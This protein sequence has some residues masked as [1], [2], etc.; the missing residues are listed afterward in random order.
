MLKC[1]GRRNMRP[2]QLRSLGKIDDRRRGRAGLY[3]SAIILVFIALTQP[4]CFLHFLRPHIPFHKKK[5]AAPAAPS[6]PSVRIMLL[7]L[8]IPPENTDL[9]WVS[10]AAPIV[11]AKTIEGSPSLEAAPLWEGMPVA[12]ESLGATRAI[13]TE[14]AAYVAS[15]VSAKWATEGELSAGK[16]GVEMLLDFIP[17]KTTMVAYRYEK[18]VQVNSMGAHFHEAFNQFLTYLVAPQMPKSEGKVIDANS[19][20]ELAEALDREY[21]W[22]VPAEPGKAGKL[23]ADLVRTDIKLARLLFNP[24]LYP[25]LGTTPAPARPLELK[26]IIPPPPEQPAPDQ[27][28]PKATPPTPG[29]PPQ[30]EVGSVTQPPPAS[31]PPEVMQPPPPPPPRRFS[32]NLGSGLPQVSRQPIQSYPPQP[33]ANPG[34]ASSA[35]SKPSRLSPPAP[36]GRAATAAPKEPQKEFRVQVFSTPNK[37]AAE[38]KASQLRKEGLRPEIEEADLKNR[39]IWYRI[40]LA[41]YG[42]REEAKEA[43]EKI[44]TSGIVQQ[45][46]L[47]P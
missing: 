32:Q 20:K 22:Y 26:P 19:V 3:I 35:S 45:Y 47:V 41:G 16:G 15:R 21:G 40:R 4:A 9:R 5:A 1:L 12:I 13:T 24:T 46:W 8:N 31:S 27:T 43:A 30:V 28:P 25:G 34:L 44:V 23:V 37:D 38:A 17:A 2:L 29:A 6:A 11:M 33:S 18:E 14:V 10:L 42:S 36:Q 39:G 7:P